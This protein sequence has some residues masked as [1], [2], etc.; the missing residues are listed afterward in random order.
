MSDVARNLVM[1]RSADLDRAKRFY[2]TLGLAFTL[3]RHGA[4]PEHLTCEMGAVAFEWPGRCGSRT[5]WKSRSHSWPGLF[6]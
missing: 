2:S 1:I 4:G 5:T 6:L 3:H